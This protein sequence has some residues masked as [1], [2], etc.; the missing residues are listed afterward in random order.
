MTIS[1]KA[2]ILA[3]AKLLGMNL[4]D[5]EVIERY[6]KYYAEALDKLSKDITPSEPTIFNRPF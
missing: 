5:D 6:E 4:S 3:V 1:D 2:K